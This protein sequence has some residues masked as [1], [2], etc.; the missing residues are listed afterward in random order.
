MLLQMLGLFTIICIATIM[1]HCL[2]T[3]P[4]HR[5][6][7]TLVHP[8]SPQTHSIA[9]AHLGVAVLESQLLPG[10]LAQP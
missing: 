8:A 9:G 4:C 7:V 1:P 3:T 5:S 10:S 6:Q 2:H